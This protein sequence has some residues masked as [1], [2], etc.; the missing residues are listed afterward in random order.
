MANTL[1]PLG[2]M[3]LET[4]KNHSIKN[5]SVTYAEFCQHERWQL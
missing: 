5:I 4:V 3:F 1:C 2:L